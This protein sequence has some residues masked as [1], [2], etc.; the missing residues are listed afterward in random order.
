MY[1]VRR[2]ALAA[3]V[4]ATA[5]ACSSDETRPATGA[6]VPTEAITSTTLSVE[7]EVEQAYLKSWDVYAEALRRLD[8]TGIENYFAE[9]YINTLR[10]EIADLISA[11]T[12]VR[13]EVEHDYEIQVVSDTEAVVVDT[14]RNHSVLLG[15]DGVPIEAD[16]NSVVSERYTLRLVEGRW[17]VVGLVAA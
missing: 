10:S 9:P 8:A 3:L 2:W 7:Q 12:P 4:L 5:V 6:T 16:P 17:L 13:V 15:K 11:G 1:G 14:Y